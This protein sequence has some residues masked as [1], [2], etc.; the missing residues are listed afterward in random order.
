M[1]L[2]LGIICCSF[3][4]MARSQPADGRGAAARTRDARRP[5][6]RLGA[7]SLSFQLKQ[8]VLPGAGTNMWVEVKSPPSTAMPVPVPVPSIYPVLLLPAT[9]RRTPSPTPRPRRPV[10]PS[11]PA[12]SAAGGAAGGESTMPA[13]RRCAANRGQ[14][15][16]RPAGRVPARAAGE[17]DAAPVPRAVPGAHAAPR[18]SSSSRTAATTGGA[19]PPAFYQS[20]AAGRSGRAGRSR[21]DGAAAGPRRRRA[22][23][24]FV[25]PSLTLR[26]HSPTTPVRAG[27][28]VY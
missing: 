19:R 7:R 5:S 15:A 2:E 18:S 21:G 1:G 4:L 20:I 22:Q 3:P 12:A 14:H 23:A 25:L 8:G 10:R 9:P 28:R 17:P 11:T 16:R 26:S 6:R 27:W 24:Q 13:P